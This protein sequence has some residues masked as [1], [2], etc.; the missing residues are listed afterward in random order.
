MITAD[1]QALA[2]EGDTK[3]ITLGGFDEPITD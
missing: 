2:V 3:V 1:P